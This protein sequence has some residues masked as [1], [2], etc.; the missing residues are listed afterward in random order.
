MC[1]IRDRS[2]SIPPIKKPPCQAAFLQK[3][4]DKFD[5]LLAQTIHLSDSLPIHREFGIRGYAAAKCLKRLIG[6]T[7]QPL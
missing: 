7:R 6:K 5:F 2:A 1:K 3:S 4:A